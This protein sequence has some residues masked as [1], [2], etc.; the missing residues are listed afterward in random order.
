MLKVGDWVTQYSA[1]FWQVTAIY[2]KFADDDYQGE[3]VTWKKGDRLGDWVVVKKGLTPKMKFSNLCECVD[4]AWC[5]PVNEDQLA[6]IHAAFLQNPKGKQKFEKASDQ[7]K[8]YVAALWLDLPE[9]RA[10]E[11]S[12]LLDT[13]PERFTDEQFRKHTA[14]F[15]QYERRSSGSYILYLFSYPWE[16]DEQFNMLHHSPQLK[17]LV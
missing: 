13:L 9:E 16:M 3:K 6:A 2:P 15:K 7:P 5:K 1:G 4:S 10:E 17:K 11:L 12:A 14:E 8:P